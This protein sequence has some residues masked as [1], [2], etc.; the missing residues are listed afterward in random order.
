[1]TDILKRFDSI[2]IWKQGEQR[3]PHKPLLILYALGR[4]QRGLP[5]VTFLE[6]EPE[7]TDLLQR[8][9]PQRKSDH[10]EQPF[11]RLQKDGVW[12][13][14]NPAGLAMK[15]G[16]DIPTVGANRP[17]ST[18]RQAKQLRLLGSRPTGLVPLLL[19]CRSW[20]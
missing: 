15:K 12:E 13:V 14:Q 19:T 20:R 8:F 18:P 6:A 1:M 5:E 4:W 3:A 16:D 7:L 17:R 2:N 9:G 11:W 10:P